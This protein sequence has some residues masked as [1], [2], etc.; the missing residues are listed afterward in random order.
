MYHTLPSDARLEGIKREARD[1]LHSARRRDA[2]ALGRFQCFDPL[3]GLSQP[4]L[5]DALYVIAREYGYCSWA[6]LKERLSQTACS[7]ALYSFTTC[8]S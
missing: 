5:S 8:Q 6:R 3:A 2:V 4:R 1:L 7:S